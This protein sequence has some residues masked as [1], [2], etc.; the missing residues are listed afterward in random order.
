MWVLRQELDLVQ[1][2]FFT[3][4]EDQSGWFYHRWLLG[5][6]L[7]CAAADQEEG[8][9]DGGYDEL[10]EV[11]SGQAQMCREL[12]E[13]QSTFASLCPPSPSRLLDAWSL[14]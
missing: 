7:T 8:G 14:R 4:P 5:A 10:R 2:A 11:L 1:Q 6:C 9:G 13:V 12:L 3:E